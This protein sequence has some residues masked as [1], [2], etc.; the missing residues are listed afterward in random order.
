MKGL[1]YK[2]LYTL[3]G[4]LRSWILVLGIMSLYT[5]WMKSSSL[6]YTL[7]I[8]NSIMTAMSAF[9]NDQVSHWESYALALPLERSD[10]VKSRY[11]FT[12]LCLAVSAAACLILSVLLGL[13]ME[14][15]AIMELLHSLYAIVIVGLMYLATLLPILYKLGVEKGRYV[16]MA[17]FISPILLL[18]LISE[19]AGSNMGQ[20][21][22]AGALWIA[23]HLALA[24]TAAGILAAVC[25]AV[26]YGISL[27]IY[28]K[29]DF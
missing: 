2:E 5:F 10:M 25:L 22:T 7:V 23:S 9:S 4:Q 29:R 8:M 20:S 11:L 14:D 24:E 27:R 21:L 6:L 13:W 3:R 15:L 19:A 16:M 1:F 12:L 28:E 17:L 26:S 18:Y